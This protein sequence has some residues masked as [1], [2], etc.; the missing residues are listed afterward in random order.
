MESRS[1]WPVEGILVHVAGEGPNG[2]RIVDVWESE[3][4]A[5]RFGELL[6][7][8]MQEIGITEQPE[9]YPVHA[10]VS[11]CRLAIALDWR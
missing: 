5:R 7:P 2:F 6:G 1:D 9:I 3:E 10:F 4:A 11:T 8:H